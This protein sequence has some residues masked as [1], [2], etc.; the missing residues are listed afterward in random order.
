MPSEWFPEYGKPLGPP[1][2]P[3][4]TDATKT[5]W[6]RRF[7]HASASVD[8]R[9]RSLSRIVWDGDDGGGGGGGIV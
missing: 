3:A 7:A 8:L 6:H 9:D 4:T 1:V 2:G 5:V